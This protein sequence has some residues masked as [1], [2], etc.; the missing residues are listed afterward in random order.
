MKN[1]EIES[2]VCKNHLVCFDSPEFIAVH[3]K[4]TRLPINYIGVG[5]VVK[6]SRGSLVNPLRVTFYLQNLHG[7]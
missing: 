6:N 7:P 2:T 3:Q 1:M 4:F 5:V